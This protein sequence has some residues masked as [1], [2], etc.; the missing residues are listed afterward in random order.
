MLGALGGMSGKLSSP[1]NWL[2]AIQSLLQPLDRYR[3]PSAIGSSIGR[4]YLTL[5]CFR[6]QV[7]LLNRLVL[8]RLGGS[9]RDS[10]AIVSKRLKPF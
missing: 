10:A 6:A 1:L 7:G 3:N 2:N 8:N 5:S 4:P 9:T